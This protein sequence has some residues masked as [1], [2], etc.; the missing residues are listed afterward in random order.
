MRRSNWPVVVGIL[1][2]VGTILLTVPFAPCP[3]CSG[4]GK[5]TV[6][7]SHPEAMGSPMTP[8][9]KLVE[10]GCPSCDGRARLSLVPPSRAAE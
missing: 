9:G 10:V 4:D 7:G 2:I 8:T 6:M 3:S 5:I 1:L